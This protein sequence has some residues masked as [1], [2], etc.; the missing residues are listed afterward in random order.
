VLL[1]FFPLSL[2]CV[3]GISVII[4][5][6]NY[7]DTRIRLEGWEVE[8]SVRAEAL[9]QFGSD[10]QINTAATAVTPQKKRTHS[11]SAKLAQTSGAIR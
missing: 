8:L 7:L 4:R 10:E 5:I 9:R 3:A 1:V 6:L 2:W 11:E